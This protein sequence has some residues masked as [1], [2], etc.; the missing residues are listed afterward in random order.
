MIEWLY[1]VSLGKVPVDAEAEAR[2]DSEGR[3]TPELAMASSLAIVLAELRQ[4]LAEAEDAGDT[5]VTTT[6][7][8]KVE[9]VE[10]LML[11]AFEQA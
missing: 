11:K 4:E 8:R 1:Q 3:A 7:K 5:M 10:D 2:M 6:V 9:L